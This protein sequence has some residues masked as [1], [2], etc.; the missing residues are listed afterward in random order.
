MANVRSAS[1]S[2]QTSKNLVGDKHAVYNTSKESDKKQRLKCVEEVSM[3]KFK[4]CLI[5]LLGTLLNFK[6]LGI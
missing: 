1:A 3:C 2:S 6:K 4:Q 5:R